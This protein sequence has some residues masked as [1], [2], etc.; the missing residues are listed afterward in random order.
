MSKHL[1]YVCLPQSKRCIKSHKIGALIQLLLNNNFWS[2]LHLSHEM[3]DDIYSFLPNF[4]LVA[5]QIF[6]VIIKN[7]SVAF[8]LKLSINVKFQGKK[9]S[10]P[11]K[12]ISFCILFSDIQCYSNILQLVFFTKLA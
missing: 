3:T 6:I 7:Q 2:D 5:I 11:V 4:R 1:D 9:N 10:N 8:D 12:R